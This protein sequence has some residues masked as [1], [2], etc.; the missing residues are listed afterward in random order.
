M[1][2]ADTTPAAAATP[3]DTLPGPWVPIAEAAAVLRVHP[4]TV[5][6]RVAA[7]TLPHRRDGRGRVLVLVEAEEPPQRRQDGPQG[8]GQAAGGL[9]VLETP[10]RTTAILA[11]LA[12]RTLAAGRAEIVQARRAAR[13]GWGVAGSVAVAAAVLVGVAAVRATALEGAVAAARAEAAGATALAATLAAT[14][15]RE[16]ERADRLVEQIAEARRQSPDTAA[17]TRGGADPAVEAAGGTAGQEPDTLPRWWAEL[18]GPLLS[19]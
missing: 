8:V 13:W 17:D 14:L 15:D 1:I 19:R 5:E 10:D 7:G 9:Q 16:V 6:R 2:T 12:D 11:G 3:P 4:R 18:V